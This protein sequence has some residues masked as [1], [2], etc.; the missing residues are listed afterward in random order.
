MS[1]KTKFAGYAMH[2]FYIPKTGKGH[3]GRRDRR[4]CK[5]YNIEHKM[6]TKIFKLCVGPSLCDKYTEII[7]SPQNLVGMNVQNKCYRLGVVVSDNGEFCT[8]QYKTTKIQCKKETLLTLI[9][10]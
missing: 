9:N 3:K 2:E 5:F 7:S 8:V 10:D 6:C 1:K 4:K